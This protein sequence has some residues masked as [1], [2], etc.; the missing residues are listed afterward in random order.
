MCSLERAVVSI[1]THA[2]LLTRATLNHSYLKQLMVAM[3]TK[4]TGGNQGSLCN[5][6]HRSKYLAIK[7]L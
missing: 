6:E 4:H 7:I 1:V 5:G 3:E 2:S